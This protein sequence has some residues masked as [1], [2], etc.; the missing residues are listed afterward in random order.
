MPKHNVSS[1]PQLSNSSTQDIS[2]LDSL[3]PLSQVDSYEVEVFA[4]SEI[5]NVL[6]NKGTIQEEFSKIS[7]MQDSMVLPRIGNFYSSEFGAVDNV[8]NLSQIDSHEVELIPN[9]EIFDV[10]DD[11]IVNA[12]SPEFGVVD[13]LGT[14]GKTDS[15]NYIQSSQWLTNIS[16]LESVMDYDYC[17]SLDDREFDMQVHEAVVA[18]GVPKLQ[19]L[20]YSTKNKT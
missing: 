3:K 20:S 2:C 17:K 5:V 6:Q 19:R 10:L 8:E 13:N 12:C 9:K 14:L 1:S 7:F 4:E 15:C 18:S 11:Q 16:V